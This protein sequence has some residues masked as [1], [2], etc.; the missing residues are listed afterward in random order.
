[1][2]FKYIPLGLNPYEFMR[3]WNTLNEG[4]NKDELFRGRYYNRILNKGGG[5]FNIILHCRY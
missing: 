3:I 1:M 5:L 4:K 2:I